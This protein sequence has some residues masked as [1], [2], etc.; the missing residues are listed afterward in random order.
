[1]MKRKKLKQIIKLDLS[2][3]V[4]MI[5][6]LAICIFLAIALGGR[7]YSGAVFLGMA[8]SIPEFALISIAMTMVIIMGGI[9]LSLVANAN[10]S[11]MIGA[12]ILSGAFFDISK[13]NIYM[14]VMGTI[15]LVLL[16]AALG[17][18]INGLIISRFSA[19][20]MIATLGTM[21]LYNGITTALSKGKAVANFPK[22]F[23][24]LGTQ[25]VAGIPLVFLIMLIAFMI[26]AFC[27]NR[28]GY[29]QKLYL[30]GE[31]CAASRFSGINNEKN[32]CI[33][34]TI[35][36]LLSGIASIVIIARSNSA[37]VGYG[38]TYLLQSVLVAVLGGVSP[39]GGKGKLE[40]TLLAIFAIYLLQNAFNL[41]QFTTFTKKFMWG[42][43]LLLVMFIT[44]IT[45]KYM[46]RL[47]KKKK[48]SKNE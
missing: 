4:L 45:E 18:L 33:T 21:T 8:Y 41:W 46:K 22:E 36:G 14:L 5:A 34:Y 29:G 17:G 40:G 2:F 42:I 9:D 23:L 31:N 24:M 15:L 19:V 25:K 37:K 10:M 26:M 3:S 7:L 28:T 16:I 32:I 39:S 35:A 27:F 1:M 12:M 48:I 30:M 43:M 13:V 6:T 38:E 20:P 11:G 47:Q 44:Q